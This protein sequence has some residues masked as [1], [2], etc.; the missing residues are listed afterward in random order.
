MNN[1]K[2]LFTKPLKFV[3]SFQHGNKPSIT[4]PFFSVTKCVLISTREQYA[5][6]TNYF[7]FCF[8]YEVI[9]VQCVISTSIQEEHAILQ[10][11]SS[12][13]LKY[14]ILS[15]WHVIINRSFISRFHT[16]SLKYNTTV[17][18]GKYKQFTFFF[19]C[20]WHAVCYPFN[21]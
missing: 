21:M 18:T 10:S 2:F 6:T 7:S 20:L 13:S 17:S 12:M 14:S 4:F 11:L 16:K 5:P 8:S 15:F 9:K 1:S 3:L 19:P